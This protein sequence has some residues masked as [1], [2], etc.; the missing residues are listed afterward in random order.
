MIPNAFCVSY[1]ALCPFRLFSLEPRQNGRAS[2]IS[3]AH[4][5]P[6]RLC[7]LSVMAVPARDLGPPQLV[8]TRGFFTDWPLQLV[9]GKEKLP[10][11]ICRLLVLLLLQTLA[12]GASS[13]ALESLIAKTGASAQ[14][15]RFP[16]AVS[17]LEHETRRFLW[18]S[19]FAIRLQRGRGRL[20]GRAAC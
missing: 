6:G 18:T 9:R 7:M 2:A 12:S 15:S 14:Q 5:N 13:L 19:R 8:L 1:G 4:R 10:G 11:A 3:P 16:I 20:E 17:S